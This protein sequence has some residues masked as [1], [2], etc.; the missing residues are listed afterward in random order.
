[1]VPLEG[2]CS[3]P[4]LFPGVPVWARAA[5]TG[6]QVSP[7]A[8]APGQG[9]AIHSCLVGAAVATDLGAQEMMTEPVWPSM[10]CLPF[11]LRIS[12][13]SL[14]HTPPHPPPHKTLLPLP[15]PRLTLCLCP[16]CFPHWGHPPFLPLYLYFILDGSSA[17]LP[18][19][20]QSHLMPQPTVAGE[21]FCNLLPMRPCSPWE[22]WVRVCSR[23]EQ[24]GNP[25][26]H[27]TQPHFR[28]TLSHLC[29]PCR[30]RG[31]L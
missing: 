12:H 27:P 28:D 25:G 24:R 29:S 16:C 13:E 8:F 3:G 7:H 30:L 31:G 19:P 26:Q 10:G 20:S 17:G 15:H 11:I 22:K 1:M 9:K 4:G 21:G 5:D 14:V 18:D 2:P 23:T 6:G